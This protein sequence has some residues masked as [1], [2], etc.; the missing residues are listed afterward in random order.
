[1]CYLL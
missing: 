1:L